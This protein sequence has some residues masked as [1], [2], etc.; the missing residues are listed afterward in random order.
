LT[1]LSREQ[2]QRNLFFCGGSIFAWSSFPRFGSQSWQKSQFLNLTE[3]LYR[4][5]SSNGNGFG[6]KIWEDEAVT[7]LCGH[8]FTEIKWFGRRLM[9]G[10]RSMDYLDA[11]IQYVRLL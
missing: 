4:F 8:A 10:S 7:A 11:W 9:R 1:N 5:S 2:F 3:W 6:A